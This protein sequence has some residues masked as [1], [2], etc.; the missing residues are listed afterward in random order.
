[1]LYDAETMYA[2]AAC[3]QAKKMQTPSLMLM[4]VVSQLVH[5]CWLLVHACW[6]LQHVL[7]H[8]MTHKCKPSDKLRPTIELATA[9]WLLQ[10]HHHHGHSL[11]KAS[12]QQQEEGIT[13]AQKQLHIPQRQSTADA[14]TTPY[15]CCL[16]GLVSW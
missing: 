9:Y 4:L 13:G 8:A 6:L 3:Q 10:I 12:I 5:A 7:S 16:Q 14:K 11:E 15:T 2:A 1:M